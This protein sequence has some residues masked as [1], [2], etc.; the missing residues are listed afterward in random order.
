MKPRNDQTPSD[1][2]LSVLISYIVNLGIA[3]IVVSLT[4]L[5]LQGVFVDAQDSAVKSEMEA[6]GQ[7]FASELERVDAM[8]SRTGADLST[9]VSLPESDNPYS[10]TVF[11]DGP[12][13]GTRINV[14]SRGTS[15]DLGF[16]N[17]T[18]IDGAADGITVPRGDEVEI[19]Y[20]SVNKEIVIE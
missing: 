4:L 11:Y 13:N 7:S 9:T 12:D 3:A 15:V 20:D 18:A 5:L 1:S 2:A 14:E 16:A 8:G 19:Q 17:T 6:I 10:V